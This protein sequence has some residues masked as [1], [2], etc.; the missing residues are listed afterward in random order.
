MDYDERLLT[1]ACSSMVPNALRLE[2]YENEFALTHRQEVAPVLSYA[3]SPIESSSS[4]HSAVTHDKTVLRGNTAI[5]YLT[6]TASD[7]L[8]HV[9]LSFN[10][11]YNVMTVAEL[12]AKIDEANMWA[13]PRCA[14]HISQ[15]DDWFRAVAQSW[16]TALSVLSSAR[17]LT[18]SDVCSTNHPNPGCCPAHDTAF[19]AVVCAESALSRF[20]RSPFE[21]DAHTGIPQFPNGSKYPI[22]MPKTWS[23]HKS[24]PHNDVFQKMAVSASRLQIAVDQPHRSFVGDIHLMYEIA[25]DAVCL[26]NE[27]NAIEAV[28]RWAESELSVLSEE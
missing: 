20:Y 15:I 1:V 10:E 12:H 21:L 2:L 27:N 8:A 17:S 23:H 16:S 19:E 6:R 3:L 9:G 7:A 22:P 14:E 11:S 4:S 24:R 28:A 13:G 26:I 25:H 18:L 5:T